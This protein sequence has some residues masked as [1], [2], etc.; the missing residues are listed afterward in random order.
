MSSTIS[1][2]EKK[3]SGVNPVNFFTFKTSAENEFSKAGLPVVIDDSFK[4]FSNYF[5]AP[6]EYEGK[7]YDSTEHAFHAAKFADSWYQEVIRNAPTP[8]ASKELGGQRAG[9]WTK[10]EVKDLIKQSKSKGVKLRP[11]WEE[12]KDQIM[13]D[14]VQIKFDTHPELKELL[15][16]T[17][18]RPICEASPYDDYWGI[19]KK[20]TGKNMLGKILMA[21]R[22]SYIA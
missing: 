8:G 7:M 14:L 2:K 4:A 19:G 9:Q 10:Q 1:I 11:D 17:G 15:L 3:A 12:V 20:G 6:I 16:S 5:E 18:S 22:D 21:V 13:Y